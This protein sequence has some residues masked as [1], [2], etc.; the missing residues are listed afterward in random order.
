MSSL[1]FPVRGPG[2]DPRRRELLRV[3][4]A[5]RAGLYDEEAPARDAVSQ[6]RGHHP[7]PGPGAR[8]PEPLV[9][10]VPAPRV[11]AV[12][13]PPVARLLRQ[14]GVCRGTR[15]YFGRF[16]EA[17]LTTC[18]LV[19]DWPGVPVRRELVR[20]RYHLMDGQFVN[21][22]GPAQCGHITYKSIIRH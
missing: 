2:V 12:L 22:R 14:R 16:T 13:H 6:R 1:Q 18:E 4:F 5:G 8:P 3:E 19:L 9:A 21:Q 10:Q 17:C 11:L 7:H 15:I 20:S